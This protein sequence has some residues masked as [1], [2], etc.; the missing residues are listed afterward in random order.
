MS[1]EILTRTVRDHF[2]SF[3]LSSVNK[4]L[5]WNVKNQNFKGE[6]EPSFVPKG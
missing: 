3:A 1:P 4:N 5:A 6:D 2:A